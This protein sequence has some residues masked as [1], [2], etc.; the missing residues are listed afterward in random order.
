MII[1][2]LMEIARRL[3]K[4]HNENLEEQVIILAN[5]DTNK[6][7]VNNIQGKELLVGTVEEIEEKINWVI[8]TNMDTATLNARDCLCFGYGKK[9][10]NK[11]GLSESLA[12]KVWTD[13]KYKMGSEF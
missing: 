13:T 12:N 11:A 9:W 4:K 5:Q 6:L 3:E 7:I 2:K 8:T 1:S 10:W